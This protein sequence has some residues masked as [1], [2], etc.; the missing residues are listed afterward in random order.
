MIE[1]LLVFYQNN[2]ATDSL[3]NIT[4]QTLLKE[5][6]AQMSFNETV[7]STIGSN[8]DLIAQCVHAIINNKNKKR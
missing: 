6:D 2:N 4:L 3:Q 8:Q 1:K 5:I 7:T